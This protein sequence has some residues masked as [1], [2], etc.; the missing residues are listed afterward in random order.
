MA[1]STGLTGFHQ[2]V[3]VTKIDRIWSIHQEITSPCFNFHFPA[4][5]G[6]VKAFRLWYS[7]CNL[8]KWFWCLHLPLGRV[9]IYYLPGQITHII[10]AVILHFNHSVRHIKIITGSAHN[11]NCGHAQTIVQFLHPVHK[12]RDGF[13][14]LM[15][16]QLHT[17]IP[18]HEI[19]SRGVLI[20]Q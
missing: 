9:F 8:T 14:I 1:Y 5:P 3:N 16:Q 13:L 12:R 11:Q 19:G 10:G 2:L 6:G 7:G 20:Q 17:G 15:N 4:A 18:D